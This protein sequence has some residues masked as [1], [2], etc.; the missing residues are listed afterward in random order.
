MNM[1]ERDFSFISTLASLCYPGDLAYFFA[2]NQK[3][4][5]PSE[6]M[7]K[8]V[9]KNWNVKDKASIIELL[10]FLLTK[11]RRHEFNHI[12]NRLL[13]L[14]EE[15]RDRFIGEIEDDNEAVKARMVRLYMNRLPAESAG[16]FDFAVCIIISRSAWKRGFLTKEESERYQLKAAQK[17][18]LSFSSW[19]EAHISYYAGLHFYSFDEKALHKFTAD[20]E[21]S[22]IKLLT[23]KSSPFLTVPWK[24]ELSAV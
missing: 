24:T 15:E 5:F 9:L 10:D 19:G 14:T 18:Q 11:G 23:L 1:T 7:A 21:D 16:A 13:F 22:T 8:K 6:R 3:P 4:V 17:A 2:V 20:L 12:R